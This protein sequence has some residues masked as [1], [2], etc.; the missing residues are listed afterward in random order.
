MGRR[1]KARITISVDPDMLAEIDA[2]VR[3]HEGT[4]RSRVIGEAL[5]GWYANVLRETLIRQDAA[6]KSP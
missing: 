1:A 3:E 4:D 5:R 2:Y 6:P